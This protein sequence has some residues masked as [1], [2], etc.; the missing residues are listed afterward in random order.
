MEK[1]GLIGGAKRLI[2][3]ANMLDLIYMAR[4]ELVRPMIEHGTLIMYRSG[5]GG[6]YGVSLR[7][8]IRDR[9]LMVGNRV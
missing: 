5:R 6:F 1:V 3:L 7:R 4:K 8:V 2:C 9:Y